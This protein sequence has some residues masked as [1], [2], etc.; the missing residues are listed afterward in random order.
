MNATGRGRS[1]ATTA[2]DG[3]A[4]TRP[5]WRIRGSAWRSARRSRT[6]DDLPRGRTRRVRN[7]RAAAVDEELRLA[8]GG[9]RDQRL[10]L[11]ARRSA[12]LVGV[13]RDGDR[14]EH[15]EDHRDDHQLH[16]GEARLSARRD[17]P[18]CAYRRSRGG[19]RRSEGRDGRHSTPHKQSM[20]RTDERFAAGNRRRTRRATSTAADGRQRKTTVFAPFRNT[21]RSRWNLTARAS[22]RHSTSR[23]SATRSSARML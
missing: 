1:S 6:R 16:Q 13:H 9:R 10:H 11:D 12:R 19:R 21:R 2:R 4:R 5:A 8:R 22:A 23:P 7:R 17:A 20:C 15:R 14:R 3:R 18:A